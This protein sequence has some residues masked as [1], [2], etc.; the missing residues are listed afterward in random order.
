MKERRNAPQGDRTG[1][2][3]LAQGQLKEE[4]WKAGEDEVQHIGNEECA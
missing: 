4:K 2:G 3:I 1:A